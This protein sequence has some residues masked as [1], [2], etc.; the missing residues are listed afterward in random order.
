M[1]K[2]RIERNLLNLVKN[3]FEKLGANII[4]N[5]EKVRSFPVKIRTEAR[6]PL[7]PLLLNIVLEVLANAIKRKK[8]EY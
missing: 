5:D 3:I 7:T 4:L 8:K 1:I 2:L 6:I